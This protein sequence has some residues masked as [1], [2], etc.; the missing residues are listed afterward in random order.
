MLLTLNVDNKRKKVSFTD[1]LI[2][3]CMEH[4]KFQ[5]KDFVYNSGTDRNH[6]SVRKSEI[7]K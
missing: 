5:A 4:L 7:T 3:V 1:K 2:P 6:R